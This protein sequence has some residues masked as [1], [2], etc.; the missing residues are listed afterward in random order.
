MLIIKAIFLAGNN[1]NQEE[2]KKD[3]NINKYMALVCMFAPPKQM[4]ERQFAD[5]ASHTSRG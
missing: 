2:E 1:F 3:G 4:R 5:K